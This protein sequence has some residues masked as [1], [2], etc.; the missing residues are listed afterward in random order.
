M[1]TS[2]DLCVFSL[3]WSMSPA[4]PAVLQIRNLTKGRIVFTLSHATLVE[5]EEV[6]LRS[7]QVSRHR[8]VREEDNK[9]D[10]GGEVDSMDGYEQSH[11][12][13]AVASSSVV[14]STTRF[15]RAVSV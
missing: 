6:S 2:T 7:R 10:L 9:V 11:Q 3:Q 4:R 13:S 5:V 8:L 12:F 1:I 14:G 15:S